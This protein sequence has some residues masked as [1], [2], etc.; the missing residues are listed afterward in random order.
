MAGRPKIFDEKEVISKAVEVFWKKGYEGS[1]ADELLTAMGIG[2]G[3][4]YLSFK[5]GKKELFEKSLKQFADDFYTD[6]QNAIAKSKNPVGYI[7]AF[8]LGQAEVT[9]ARQAQGCYLGNGL[10]EMSTKDVYTKAVVA[11]LL[12]RMEVI[13]AKTIRKA[14]KK[15][16]LK[17]KADPELLGRYLLNLWNGLN[18][19]RRMYPMDPALKEVIELSLQVLK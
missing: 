15:K 19:T 16:Q 17:T 11:A 12:A 7:K 13:F 10:I 1:S 4:F 9:E 5:G 8:F 14:Q 3:S 6:F 18:V 2:K